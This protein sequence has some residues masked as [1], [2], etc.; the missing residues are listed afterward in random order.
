M[1]QGVVRCEPVDVDRTARKP[2]QADVDMGLTQHNWS[3]NRAGRDPRQ[4]DEVARH[5]E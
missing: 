4:H 5:L 1:L 3:K 2:A